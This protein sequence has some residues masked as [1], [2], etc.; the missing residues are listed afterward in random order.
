MAERPRQLKGS[1]SITLRY[2]E[3]AHAAERRQRRSRLFCV[4]EQ[5]ACRNAAEV[6]S[7]AA[8]MNGVLRD[9]DGGTTS[10]ASAETGSTRQIARVCLEYS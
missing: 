9:S 10:F 8:D 1:V 3:E 4:T 5:V 7:D 6:E 2:A